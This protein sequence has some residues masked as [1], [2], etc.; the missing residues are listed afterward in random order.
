MAII[1]EISG[2]QDCIWSSFLS[3][4]A[5]AEPSKIVCSIF[6]SN[7]HTVILSLMHYLYAQSSSPMLKLHI[8]VFR[9]NDIS[10]YFINWRRFIHGKIFLSHTTSI[11]TKI[12]VNLF[13]KNIVDGCFKLCFDVNTR[14]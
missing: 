9:M 5:G 4:R 12:C 8:M 1:C 13:R 7:L 10:M 14:V 3:R 11:N 2:V 6:F